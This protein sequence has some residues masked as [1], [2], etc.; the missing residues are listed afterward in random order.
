MKLPGVPNDAVLAKVASTMVAARL[1]NENWAFGLTV[2]VLLQTK[3]LMELVVANIFYSKQLISQ[4]TFSAI[5]M[6]ALVS[7]ALTI[8]L[9]SLLLVTFGDKL[10]PR[11]KQPAVVAIEL[12]TT[13]EP[14]TAVPSPTEI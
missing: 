3:G 9:T 10:I 5:V 7:T 6:V 2:G 8:P 13:E 1:S 4:T 14:V 12:P 11:K